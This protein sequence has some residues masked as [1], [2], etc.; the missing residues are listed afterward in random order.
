MHLIPVNNRRKTSILRNNPERLLGIMSLKL[1]RHHPVFSKFVKCFSEPEQWTKDRFHIDSFGMSGNKT[2]ILHIAPMNISGVPGQFV[3]AQRRLG[4]DSRLVTLFRDK[5]GYYEDICLDLPF[6]DSA[7]TRWLKQWV[8]NPGKLHV[9]NISR[10]PEKIP[11]VWS[12][13][14]ASERLFVRL[15]D[16][17]WTPR[18]EWA[19]RRYELDKFDVIQL[20]GGLGLYRSGKFVQKLDKKIIC[21]YTGSDLRTRGVIKALDEKAVVNVTVEFDHLRLHPDIHHVFFP[22]DVKP[23]PRR[24]PAG[25]IL[26]IG[27]APTNRAAKGSDIIIPVLE[28]L[29]REEGIEIDLIENLPYRE[30]IERKRRCD[31]FVDQIG[32]LGY[33]INALEALAMEIPCCSCLA[34]G[35][36]RIYPDHPFIQTDGADLYDTLK[37]L[38]HRPEVIREKGIEGREWVQKYHDP[39]SVVRRIHELA[40]IE[41]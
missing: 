38:I 9:D 2:K 33:G 1:N 15:R 31:V 26:R 41:D 17:I 14:S 30:A 37:D 36:A 23:F 12:P 24:H 21:C 8:S 4:F 20:D 10:V 40:G 3:H 29:K 16:L 6:I 28:R 35:F 22:F 25:T 5:R 11:I 13:H 19:I 32:D 27:H 34:A 18:I 7:S 39:L